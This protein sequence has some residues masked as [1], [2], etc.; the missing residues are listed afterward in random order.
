MSLPV[1][2]RLSIYEYVHATNDM[3]HI[4]LAPG[5]PAPGLPEYHVRPVLA[6]DADGD[7]DSQ[8]DD[9]DHYDDDDDDDVSRKC[10]NA[11]SAQMLSPH[12]AHGKMPTALLLA[13]RTI[14]LEARVVPFH[15]GELVFR[16]WWSSG[17]WSASVTTRRMAA[18]QQE[19]TRYA[20]VE[21]R[22][23]D[24]DRR[25]AVARWVELCGRWKAGLRGM[26]LRIAQ[27]SLPLEVGASTPGLGDGSLDEWTWARDGLGALQRLE[28][29]EVEVD[30]PQTGNRDKLEWCEQL[31]AVLR[32]EAKTVR[33]A[34]VVC[35][36][37]VDAEANADDVNEYVM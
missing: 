24:L 35:V 16:N 28:R 21:L 7:A 25:E 22:A 26:R 34:E 9:G 1:E 5:Y 31:Q 29:L 6:D 4:N 3:T 27:P 36:E 20:R 23:G 14:Y 8:G 15:R 33:P 32:D 12:R 11:R 10:A 30:V 18:W 19:E 37:R 2:I 13:N 17:A